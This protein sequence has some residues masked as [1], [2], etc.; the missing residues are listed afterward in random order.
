MDGTAGMDGEE[1]IP[2]RIAEDFRGCQEDGG[3]AEQHG[4]ALHIMEGHTMEAITG[5]ITPY[6]TQHIRTAI[7]QARHFHISIR[8][9]P[10]PSRKWK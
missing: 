5:V 8:P 4:T 2:T 7:L 10:H 1:V 6:P 9:P 3:G